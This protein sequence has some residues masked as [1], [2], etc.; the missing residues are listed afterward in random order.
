MNPSLA[1]ACTRWL[2]VCG[3]GVRRPDEVL[4]AGD[5]DDQLAGGQVLGLG[6]GAPL[7]GRRDRVAVHPHA[8]PALRDGVLADH[9]VDRGQRP[10]GVVVGQ[11]AVPQ[12]FE[13]LDRRLRR[14]LRQPD[15]VGDVGGLGVGVAEDERRGGQ[16]EQVLGRCAR[17]WPGGP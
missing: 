14:D 11:V 10:V 15:V 8:G 4:P 3:D 12:L 5:L 16:D 6:P 7:V 9:R 1:S 2:I 17:T 13:E